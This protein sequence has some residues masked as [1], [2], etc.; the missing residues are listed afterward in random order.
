MTSSSTTAAWPLAPGGYESGVESALGGT[1]WRSLAALGSAPST[2]RV[3]APSCA[4][5]RSVDS[6]TRRVA[7]KSLTRV[8]IEAERIPSAGNVVAP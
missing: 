2:V 8:S 3:C 1:I 6:T 7:R 5:T 4:V